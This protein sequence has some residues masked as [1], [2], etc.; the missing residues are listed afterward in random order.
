MIPIPA[1]APAISDTASVRFCRWVCGG[2]WRLRPGQDA[3]IRF[4]EAFLFRGF[5]K[6]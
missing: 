4:L 1:S 6:P 3:D 2:K 5:L